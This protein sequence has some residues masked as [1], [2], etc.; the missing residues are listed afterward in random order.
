M[1]EN[2][3]LNG[4]QEGGEK[5]YFWTLKMGF[6]RL[7]DFGPCRGRGGLQAYSNC[8]KLSCL[9]LSFFAYSCV[10]EFFCLQ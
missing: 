7:P 6:P 2:G 5:G 3:H 1:P 9:P 10:W 8:W 4:S